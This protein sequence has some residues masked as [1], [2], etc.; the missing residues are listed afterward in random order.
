M[1]RKSVAAGC[2]ALLSAGMIAGCGA[3]EGKYVREGMNFIDSMEYQSAL[4][5]FSRALEEKENERLAYRGMGIA[6]MGL[7]EYG[8]AVENFQKCLQLSDGMVQDVDFDVNYYLAAAYY[9]SGQYREAEKTCS[10]ILALRPKELKAYLYRGKA[11]LA[12]DEYEKAKEDFDC[13]IKKNPQDYDQLIEIYTAYEEYGYRE[14][15]EE[16]L[17]QILAEYSDSMGDYDRGRICY[18]LQDYVRACQYLEQSKDEK[19]ADSCLYLG[20]AYEATGDYNYAAS[21]YNSFVTE[22]PEDARVYNQLGLCR[23][24]QKEYRQALEAFQTAM[25]IEDNN[26]M[27][28]L[29]YNEIVA[30]EYLGDYK[31]A[32]VLMENYISM[33]P[34]DSDAQREA[35]F[36][37]T[38]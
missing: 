2:F 26:M 25:N 18:Y 6:Y 19:S 34:D 21:V 11:R 35:K 10:A 32:S 13:L 30:L 33:Y 3:S 20:K 17:K 14:T 4:E 8:K 23:M 31:K 9:K 37:K 36:L 1:L 22:N 12:M 15:G 7:T 24:K 28:I 29:R 38:R 5:D 16:N 27:Q